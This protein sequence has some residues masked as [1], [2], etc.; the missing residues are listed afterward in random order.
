MA[1]ANIS[2]VADRVWTGGDLPL[3]KGPRAMRAALGAMTSAGITHVIDNRLEWTDERFV[4]RYAPAVRYLWNGQDDVGQAMPD[5]WFDRGVTFALLALDDPR[6]Q[7]LAHC[8]MGINRG[9]SM[10]F[11]ILLA[12]GMEPVAALAAIRHARP[13]AAISY[14]DD[15]LDWW[16]RATGTPADLARQQ[17]ADVAAWHGAHPVDI[18]RIIRAIRTQEHEVRRLSA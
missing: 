9:P 11:A 6:A 12:T 13:I 10:A 7:V 2:R 15:A 5:S 4:A 18:I 1:S 14:S 16:Q 8:H 17:R 3:H